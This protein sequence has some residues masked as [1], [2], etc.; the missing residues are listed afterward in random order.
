L[1]LIGGVEHL[2]QLRKGIGKVRHVV[3]VGRMHLF[4]TGACGPSVP[5]GCEMR[6]CTFWATSRSR[7]KA[8]NAFVLFYPL[9]FLE[10]Y[11]IAFTN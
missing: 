1:T 2:I 4:M 6:C 11:D 10:A 8:P 7:Q 9:V 3:I 5:E